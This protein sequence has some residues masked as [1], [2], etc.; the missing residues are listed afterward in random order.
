MESSILQP[1]KFNRL[2]TQAG[3]QQT[4]SSIQCQA[5]SYRSNL[6]VRIVG[7]CPFSH[8]LRRLRDFQIAYFRSEVTST[9]LCPSV[10]G[11]DA[12]P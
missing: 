10:A 1:V 6:N 4:Y 7:L 9:I 2:K 11:A 8:G 5:N 3:N 12:Q